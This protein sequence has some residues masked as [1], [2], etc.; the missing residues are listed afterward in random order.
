MYG[1]ICMEC[2]SIVYVGETECEQ[3]E[4]MTEHIWDIR[5]ERDKPMHFHFGEGKKRTE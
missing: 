5:L 2:K 3:N 4:R 1:I